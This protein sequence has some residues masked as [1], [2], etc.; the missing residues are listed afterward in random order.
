MNPLEGECEKGHLFKVVVNGVLK[1]VF[2]VSLINHF[3]EKG[4]PCEED[5]GAGES[6]EGESEREEGSHSSR[7]THLDY[8]L[9]FRVSGLG[10]RV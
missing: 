9:G 6:R 5:P 1:V 10:F 2:H 4:Y 8:G 3:R 7:S